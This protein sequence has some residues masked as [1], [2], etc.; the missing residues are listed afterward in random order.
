MVA[1][2]HFEISSDYYSQALTSCTLFL[3]NA[4]SVRSILSLTIF[5]FRFWKKIEWVLSNFIEFL[6]RLNDVD[7]N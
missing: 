3:S 2:N 4:L 1:H 7:E 5:V 6:E